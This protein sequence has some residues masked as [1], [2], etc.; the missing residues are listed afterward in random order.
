MVN[1]V[2]TALNQALEA[3]REQDGAVTRQGELFALPASRRTELDEAI[4]AAQS[5]QAIVDQ[6]W[7]EAEAELD[8]RQAA[9]QADQALELEEGAR[10]RGRPKGSRNLRTEE[11]ARFYIRR[12]GD[13][14]EQ[15]VK[16][17]AIPIL[18]KG[19]LEALAQRL[20]CS[21]L[22]AAK[23]WSSNSQG[24][25]PYI[26]PKLGS[27]EIIPPG[28]PNSDEVMIWDPWNYIDGELVD[29]TVSEPKTL[30]AQEKAADAAVD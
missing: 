15:A 25:M 18:A 3:H 7:R 22:D 5:D 11:A 19:V 14:L 1:G 20:G 28:S 30:E 27:I 10:R 2:K 23:W 8:Q 13:P 12:H 17:G 26:R 24:V 9:V 21:K 16:I 4:A 6:A 29:N